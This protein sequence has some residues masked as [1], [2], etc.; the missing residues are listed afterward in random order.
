[1]AKFSKKTGNFAT[2]KIKISNYYNFA[3]KDF[4]GIKVG[5]YDN[6]AVNNN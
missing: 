2:N 1:M 5:N 6:F 3:A 4:K